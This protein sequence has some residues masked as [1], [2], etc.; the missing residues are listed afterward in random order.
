MK[1]LP[2]IYWSLVGFGI[3]TLMVVFTSYITFQIRNKL[4]KIPSESIR[5]EDRIKKTKMK[6]HDRNSSSVKQHH[7]RIVRKRN[8]A[9]DPRNPR[10]R[11]KDRITILNDLLKEDNS[12]YNRFSNN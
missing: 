9:D 4:G 12:N 7:P 1:L 10:Q 3:L 2:I 8:I 5:K 6:F 11:S